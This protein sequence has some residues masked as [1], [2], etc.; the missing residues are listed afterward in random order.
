MPAS[1]HAKHF[2]PCGT[3]GEALCT[4]EKS[5]VEIK[6]LLNLQLRKPSCL[7]ESNL[8]QGAWRQVQGH[9]KRENTK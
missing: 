2:L 5:R 7:I 3:P 6:I 1:C 4:K 8:Y 9:L